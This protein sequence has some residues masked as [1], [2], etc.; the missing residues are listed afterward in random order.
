MVAGSRQG[1]AATL[2]FAARIGKLNGHGTNVGPRSMSTVLRDLAN[3]IMVVLRL[4][5]V[6]SLA[7]YTMSNANAAMHGSAFSDIEI[8]VVVEAH[9]G[10]HSDEATS[11]QKEPGEHAHAGHHGAGGDG[12]QVNK[13]C[14]QDFCFSI[15]LPTLSQ[16]SVP[17]S[18][19][20][21]FGAFNDSRVHGTRPSLHRPPKI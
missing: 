8:A 19:S 17:A 20:T 1:R 5:V 3:R 21:V 13:D 12:K 2:I 15:A 9:V 10:V 4:V 14:C 7:G 11:H 6:I 18:A 16:T